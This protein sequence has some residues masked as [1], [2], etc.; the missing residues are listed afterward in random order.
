MN[1]YNKEFF[2]LFF[3]FVGMLMV[4]GNTT[5]VKNKGKTRVY[6]YKF[7]FLH[8]VIII[9]VLEHCEKRSAGG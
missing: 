5:A 9:E 8:T 7:F 2:D 4:L 3:V 6:A 1:C